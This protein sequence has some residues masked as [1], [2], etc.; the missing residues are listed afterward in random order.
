MDISFLDSERA[1][2][3]SDAIGCSRVGEVRH[4]LDG[5][6]NQCLMAELCGEDLSSGLESIGGSEAPEDDRGASIFDYESQMGVI[7]EELGDHWIKD[8]STASWTRYVVVPR[9]EFCH[10][11]QGEGGPDLSVLSGRRITIPSSGKM[12][13]DNWK[14]TA[15][16]DGPM[17]GEP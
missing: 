6:L 2:N 1:R 14:S 17:N 9:R 11:S 8:S 10:P 4:L 16:E 5:R 12:V 13:R 15:A 3:L 7:P